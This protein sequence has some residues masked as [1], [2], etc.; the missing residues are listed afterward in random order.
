MLRFAEVDGVQDLDPVPVALEHLAAFHDDAAF[1]LL[2][3]GYEEKS[4]CIFMSAPV[5]A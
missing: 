2:S 1:W 5:T 3:I 4:I